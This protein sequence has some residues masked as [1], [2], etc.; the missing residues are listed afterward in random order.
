ML[1]EKFCKELNCPLVGSCSVN[2]ENI[3]SKKVVLNYKGE[4]MCNRG[5]CS[6]YTPDHAPHNCCF[7]CDKLY[8]A[9]I[10]GSS[11]KEDT[12][13]FICLKGLIKDEIR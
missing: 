6:K 3:Q 8:N 13:K 4:I 1:Y 10:A 9:C 11:V 5:F 12:L 2:T 7:D